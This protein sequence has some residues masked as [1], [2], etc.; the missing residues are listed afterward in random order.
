[1]SYDVIQ[2]QPPTGVSAFPAGSRTVTS[3]IDTSTSAEWVNT[4]VNGWQPV[5]S[6]V[7]KGNSLAQTSTLASLLTFTAPVTGLYA[8]NTYTV[9][10]TATNGT[11]PVPTVTFTEGDTGTAGATATTVASGTATTGAGQSQSG[12]AIV[13]AKA[14]TPIVVSLGAPTTLTYNAKARISYI[15]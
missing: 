6:A 13:N 7:A 9:Q 5:S 10:A 11:L 4:G 2:G 3:A 1:M 15:G 14:G 12:Q 8:V